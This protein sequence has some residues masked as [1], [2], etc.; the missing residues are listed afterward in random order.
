MK[1][2]TQDLLD[3]LIHMEKD[4][5]AF[6]FYWPD[7]KSILD[8]ITSECAEISEAI[9]SNDSSEHI[10]EELGDLLHAVICLYVFL[11]YD[12]NETLSLIIKKFSNRM[13]LMRELTKEEGLTNL[14]GQNIDFLLKLWGKAKVLEKKD[15]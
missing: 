13:R 8:Q 15:L 12:V 14:Q 11:N 6:G 1:K 9:Q 5:R 4:C 2:N 10:Q 7:H 3:E